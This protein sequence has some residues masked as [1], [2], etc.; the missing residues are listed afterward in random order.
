MKELSHLSS[1]GEADRA[2]S[3]HLGEETAQGDLIIKCE[4]LMGEKEDDGA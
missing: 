4:S 2:R 1:R 3:L